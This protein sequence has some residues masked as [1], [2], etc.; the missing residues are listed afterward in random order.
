MTNQEF[1]NNL[2]PKAKSIISSYICNDNSVKRDIIVYLTNDYTRVNIS[3]PDKYIFEIKRQDS[4]YDMEYA[5]LH[6]FYHCVQK[7]CGFPNITYIDNNY[8]NTSSYIASIILDCDVYNRLLD[9]GY[10]E[11]PEILHKRFLEIQALFL[12]L[13]E[14]K[15]HASYLDPIENQILYAGKLLLLSKYYDKKDDVT[16]LLN[17]SKNLYPAIYNDY[18]IFLMRYRDMALR[19]QKVLEKYLKP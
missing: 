18:R 15:E 3:D 8:Q 7:D 16:R 12:L 11:N 6:E 9:D 14:E 2:S 1:I 19:L 10:K 17:F 13:R 4:F 5:L